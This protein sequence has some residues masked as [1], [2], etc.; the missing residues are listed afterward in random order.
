[1]N[2][3]LIAGLGS[4]LFFSRQARNGGRGAS[5]ANVTVLSGQKVSRQALVFLD[6]LSAKLNGLHL[7]VTSGIRAPEDQAR[8]MLYKFEHRGGA[9]ELRSLYRR[10]SDL[11]DELLAVEPT[12]ANWTAV[13]AGQV[14]RGRLLSRHLSARAVDLRTRDWDQGTTDLV[15]RTAASMGA[16]A[17]D[18]GDHLHLGLPS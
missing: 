16:N 9:D 6:R 7:T 10:N 15:Q 17:L 5:T 4:L 11:I 2:P 13:I 18:E 12:Q 1:M 14:D 8:A 3:W